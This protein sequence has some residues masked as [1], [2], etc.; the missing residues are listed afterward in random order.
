MLSIIEQQP[1]IKIYSTCSKCRHTQEPQR[2]IHPVCSLMGALMSLGGYSLQT[3]QEN[4]LTS[5]AINGV[6][7]W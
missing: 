5:D 6:S 7:L 4:N 3:K 2:A 1:A